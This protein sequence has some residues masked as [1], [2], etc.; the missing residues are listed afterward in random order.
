MIH[1]QSKTAT[2][3]QV[4]ENIG[5]MA[6]DAAL[7]ILQGKQTEIAGRI[8]AR[9][10]R[11]ADIPAELEALA[12]LAAESDAGQVENRAKAQALRGEADT[13]RAEI[14]AIR[15][16]SPAIV[17]GL[18][19]ALHDAAAQDLADLEV[20]QAQA[21]KVARGAFQEYLKAF[22]VITGI[23]AE[24]EK[25]LRAQGIARQAAKLKTVFLTFPATSRK[26]V[27]A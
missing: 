1:A 2:G 15:A 22:A 3:G 8:S 24:A 19:Q 18:A 6:S 10:K 9:E 11:L 16:G 25:P 21:V 23:E 4:V 27:E 5:G 20:R 17:A 12:K 14:E 7:A 13:I 26:E